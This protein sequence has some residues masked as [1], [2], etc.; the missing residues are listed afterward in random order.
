[1][2]HTICHDSHDSWLQQCNAV[3]LVGEASSNG[4]QAGDEIVSANDIDFTGMCQQQ[5]WSTLK[6]LPDGC[7]RLTVRRN[8]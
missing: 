8:R 4:L 3:V 7:I 6:S 2:C 1:M 5:A